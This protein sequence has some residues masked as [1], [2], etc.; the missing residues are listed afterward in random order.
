MKTHL[1]K[2]DKFIEILGWA[3]VFTVWFFTIAS[4]S[5]LPETIPIHYSFSGEAD[6]FGGKGNIFTSP[7]VATIF[8]TGLTILNKFPKLFNY[9]NNISSEDARRLYRNASRLIRYLKLFLV[10]IFGLG[11]FQTIRIAIGQSSELGVWFLPLTLGL[12]FLPIIYFL[13]KGSRT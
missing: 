9:P 2:A 11:S 7:L 5:G 10:I 13:I 12:I 3:L 1:T 6:A 8:F 4:Y